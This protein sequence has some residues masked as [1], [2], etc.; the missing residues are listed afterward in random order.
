MVL[1]F[2]FGFGFA[3]V[4]IF[5]VLSGYV[6][7]LSTETLRPCLATVGR[8]VLRRGTRLDP[9]YL[10]SIALAVAVLIGYS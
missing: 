6:I 3:G 1:Q 7:A 9:P 8:F 10:V 4:D 2:P 5:F